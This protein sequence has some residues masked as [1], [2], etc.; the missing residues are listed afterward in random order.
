[1][2]WMLKI[3]SPRGSMQGPANLHLLSWIPHQHHLYVNIKEM[4]QLWWKLC[5]HFICLSKVEASI[6]H[7]WICKS[8]DCTHSHSEK[9]WLLRRLRK[10]PKPPLTYPKNSF[11]PVSPS[12]ALNETDQEVSGIKHNCSDLRLVCFEIWWLWQKRCL[13]SPTHPLK[14][15][16]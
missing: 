16:H 15:H 10:H 12:K 14:A 3:K 7:H 11:A 13:H 9:N 5:S 8:E 1:M 2:P 6:Q 4:L